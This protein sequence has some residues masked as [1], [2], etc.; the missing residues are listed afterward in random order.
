[1]WEVTGVVQLLADG[2]HE[3]LQV[4]LGAVDRRG[5]A[6]GSIWP[7]HPIQALVDGSCQPA[8]HGGQGDVE[9]VGDVAQGSAGTDGFEHLAASVFCTWPSPQ[10]GFLPC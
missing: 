5:Q 2:Q 7:I 6:A 3:V 9:A 4:T 10:Q 8:L 1:L